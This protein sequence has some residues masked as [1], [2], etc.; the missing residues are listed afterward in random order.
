M[1]KKI[2]R[3]LKTTAKK[4]GLTGKRADAYIHGTMHRTKKRKK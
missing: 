3:K 2:H 1:P 4:K